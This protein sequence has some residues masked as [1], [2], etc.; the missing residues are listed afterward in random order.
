ME[1]YYRLLFARRLL[2]SASALLE[3]PV[4]DARP[5]NTFQKVNKKHVTPVSLPPV[6][7]R[8]SSNFMWTRKM[9]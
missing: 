3:F 8:L 4:A 2:P 6:P 5:P 7:V 1:Q 9:L